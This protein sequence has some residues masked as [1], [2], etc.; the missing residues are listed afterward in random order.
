MK[1]LSLLGSIA[2][3]ALLSQP[4]SAQ[5]YRDLQQGSQSEVRVSA[6][7]TIPFGG[8]KRTADTK[9]QFDLG[10]D[11]RVQRND[12]L[13]AV[14]PA[15]ANEAP[16]WRRTSLSLTLEDNPRML[17]NGH[18]VARFNLTTHADEDDAG[19]TDGAGGKSSGGGVSPWLIGGAVV[20]GGLTWVTLEAADEIGDVFRPD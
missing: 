4:A 12:V 11:Q 14:N 19:E 10:F 18:Q 8:Q 9:P 15:R 20:I 13:L 3:V 5:S 1:T 2:V 16:E 6:G 17:M 7:I